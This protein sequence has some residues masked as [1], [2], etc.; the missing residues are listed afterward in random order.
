MI[1]C[2]PSGIAY[3]ARCYCLP[4]DR[5]RAAWIYSLCAWAN[6]GGT[7]PCTLPTAP[8]D[9]GAS[10]GDGQVTLTWPVGVGAT[11]YNIKRTLVPGGPYTV[12]GTSA[13]SPYVDLT[14]ANGTTYYYVVSSTNA[15]GE[16]S[17]N[18]I[19]SHA[20]PVPNVPSNSVL[21]VITGTAQIG[22]TLS[23]SNGTW[24][25]SPTGYT[26]RWL[27]NSVAIGGATANTFTLLTAQIGTTI[28]FEV[29]ASN[30]GGSGTPATSSA[31]GTVLG[32]SFQVTTTGAGQVLTI[33]ALTVSASMT[34]DWGDSS[35]NAYV[36][37][38][39]RTHTY[40]NAGTYVVQFLAPLLVT[41]LQLS[42]SKV[43]LNSSQIKS[44][45]N[46]TDFEIGA[47]KAGTFNSADITSWSPGTFNLTNM[48]AGYAGTF[49]FS[50]ISSWRPAYFYLYAMPTGYSGS[51]NTSNVSAWRPGY[52]LVHDIP[53]ATFTT[54][55]TA[56]GFSAWIT[57]RFITMSTMGLTQ[58]QVN[59]ILTDFYTAF[60]TRTVT[61]GTIT[62]NGAGNAAP[63][64]I[65]QSACPPT[66]GK[67]TAFDL[68]NDLCLTN[69]TKTWSTIT[70][71]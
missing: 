32:A 29:T 31:T 46:V 60:A 48:P 10:A 66:S 21:P 35:Q 42:D 44:I 22:F 62:L 17:G 33:M 12:I 41:A 68:I 58:G 39:T 3:S 47:L 54:T 4:D 59:Q 55:I 20:T 57:T 13:A 14:A 56:G 15:C 50:D 16:S 25:N 63:S 40:T 38:G 5:Q 70:T 8:V 9:L 64:G 43:T 61:G 26:Y 18:S 24:S 23:G 7:P 65:Y 28:T 19:E 52:F 27:A 69:P 37:A 2:S 67:E 30:T 1:D 45:A 49:N 71:N 53:T 51:L 36:G 34:V 6:A 11:G